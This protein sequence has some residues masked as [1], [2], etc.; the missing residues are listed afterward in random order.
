M[1][2]DDG[3][4]LQGNYWLTVA[5]VLLAL[6]PNIIVTTAIDLLRPVLV[7]GLH[8]SKNDLGLSP[9]F[10]NAGYAFGAVLAAD[11]FQRFRQ[12]RLYLICE[13]FFIIGAVLSAVA[14][15][16]GF[17]IAGRII[18]GFSTGLLL[19]VA[20]P[21]LIQR[22]PVSRLPITAAFVNIGF[23]GAVTVGPLVGGYVAQTGT[24]R[25]FFA[26]LAVLGTLGFLIGLFLLPSQDPPNPSLPFDLTAIPLAAAGT[27]LTFYGVFGLMA[28]EWTAPIVWIPIA[29]GV[30]S[31]VA[32]LIIQYHKEEPLVP[33][34]PLS[35]SL[36]VI[37]VICA[38]VAGGAF[39]ALLELLETFLV[40][41]RNLKPLATGILF[42]PQVATIAVAA[43]LFG[44]LFKTRFLPVLALAGMLILTLAAGLLT[45]LSLGSGNGFILIVAGLLGLGAGLTVSPGLFTAAFGVPSKQIGRTFALVEL[46]RSA[47]A[48]LIGPVML[49]FA[50]SQGATPRALV[51][52]FHITFW[53][54][55]GLLVIGIAVLVTLFLISKVRLRPPNLEGW[56]NGDEQALESPPVASAAR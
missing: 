13:G 38:M 30:L 5:L 50:L 9:A 41:A 40:Q 1:A 55:F 37:G 27:G 4:P 45:Q 54:T 43:L 20:L 19:V 6:C 7:T 51:Q 46:L 29:L 56:L 22:F 34:K 26:V 15:A 8:T 49:H 16:A 24:W 31:L 23:F 42:W 3:P 25:A 11:L 44:L 18:Q 14:P 17:F 48:Y 12:R 36:P 28:Q 32:L 47:A 53:A 35:T 52:G 21:P 2:Q 33:V 10:S 39:V